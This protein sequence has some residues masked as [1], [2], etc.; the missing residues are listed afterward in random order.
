MLIIF[1]FNKY[2]TSVVRQS[3]NGIICVTLMLI[4][5]SPVC[6]QSNKP[7]KLFQ[8][9]LYCYLIRPSRLYSTVIYVAIVKKIL[10]LWISSHFGLGNTINK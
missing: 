7:K 9:V 3:P 5:T 8:Y 4:S 2:H 1:F 10:Y 6:K